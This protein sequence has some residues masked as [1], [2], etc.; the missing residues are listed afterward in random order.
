MK[1]NELTMYAKESKKLSIIILS[2]GNQA[3]LPPQRIH[4]V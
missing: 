2:E 3:P 4:T 1:K